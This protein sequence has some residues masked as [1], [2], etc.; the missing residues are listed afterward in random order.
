[1]IDIILTQIQ[2]IMTQAKEVYHVDPI[3]FLAIH[4]LGAAGRWRG[5]SWRVE[6]LG[7][8]LAKS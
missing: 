1:M 5:H 7:I 4:F 6:R 8:T 2:S 3:I